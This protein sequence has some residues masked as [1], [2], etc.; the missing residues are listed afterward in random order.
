MR[1]A[2]GLSSAVL[3]V[4]EEKG[5]CPGWMGEWCEEG[6]NGGQQERE[7]SV[8]AD[9]LRRVALDLSFSGMGVY[10]AVAEGW[11]SSG[12]GV[13]LRARDSRLTWLSC[14]DCKSFD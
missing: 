4:E 3:P 10:N 5:A 8:M 9:L 1:L 11:F 13:R 12:G 14:R 6:I 2:S 7:P